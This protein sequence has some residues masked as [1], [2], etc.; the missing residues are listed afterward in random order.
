MKG[1]T[2]VQILWAEKRAQTIE[3]LS[4]R[5]KIWVDLANSSPAHES[6]Q[7][8]K[9]ISSQLE[10]D[11]LWTLVNSRP[12]TFSFGSAGFT[13]IFETFQ[14]WQVNRNCNGT[15]FYDFFPNSF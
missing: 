12:E 3:I 11:R 10:R 2:G 15:T 1:A 13:C 5:M 6:P 4:I 8:R 9:T 14:Y 7:E